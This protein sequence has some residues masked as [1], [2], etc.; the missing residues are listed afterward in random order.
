MN[1]TQLGNFVMECFTGW[2]DWQ[3]GDDEAFMDGHL[4]LEKLLRY[5]EGHK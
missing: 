2:S 1:V 5:L 4:D 3:E